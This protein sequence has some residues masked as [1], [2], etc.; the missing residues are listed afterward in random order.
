MQEISLHIKEGECL[1]IVGGTGSGK[2]TL[3]LH[4]NGLLRPERGKIYIAGR[5]LNYTPPELKEIRKR[6]GLLFQY[7]EHQLFG[8]NVF[9]DVS[10]T[11]ARHKGISSSAIKE[12][13]KVA[14]ALVGLED[15]NFWNRSPWELSRGEMRRVALAGVLVQDPQVLILDEPTVGLD[16]LGKKEILA[17]I[18]SFHKEGRTVIIIVHEVEEI[19]DLVDRLIV[20]DQGKIL[21]EGNPDEVLSHLWLKRKFTFL[22]PPLYQL[23]L[24]LRDKGRAIPVGKWRHEEFIDFYLAGVLGQKENNKNN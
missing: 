24:E 14:C 12:K 18:K 1:G 10:F 20:L 15:E 11:L 3:A 16:A 17:W 13:V 4:F 8:K 6:I 22:I 23:S 9:E 19:L 7:P 2:T 5:E 21:T